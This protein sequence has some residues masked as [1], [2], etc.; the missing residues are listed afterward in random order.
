M[1]R[2]GKL[3]NRQLEE[4]IF[5]KLRKNRTETVTGAGVGK[6]CAVLDLADNYCVLSTDPITASEDGLGKLCVN[7]STNDI[8]SSGAES[9][10]IMITMLIP[11]HESMENVEKVIDEAISSCNE[12]NI[13][14]IGGHT[15]VT[16]AVNRIILSAVA[17]GKMPKKPF[18]EVVAGDKLV[19]SKF[20][21]TEGIG[22]I[23]SAHSDK[24]REIL[25]EEEL[26]EAMDMLNHTSVKQEGIIGSQMNVKLMHDATEGG[27]LG[28]AWEMADNASLGLT[29]YK[30]LIPIK[31]VSVKT[32]RFFN[33]DPYRLISSGV[34][35][36]A[37]DNAE[38]LKE[39]LL[40][41]GINAEI[42][43]EFTEAGMLI[44]EGGNTYE[45]TPPESDELYK[46]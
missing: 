11:P 32:A 24:L 9:V 3:T 39:E 10:A 33:I 42:I 29:V 40:R 46:L 44:S 1:I 31:D 15:E 16:D 30:D 34:M 20:A 26:L 38:Q 22:I 28:A 13:D 41:N 19:M 43:G 27:V 2:E 14:L 36:F 21:A 7:I 37:T 8:A 12:L 35:L 23:S 17:I 4:M 18:R 25:S 6:D 45:L 5:S